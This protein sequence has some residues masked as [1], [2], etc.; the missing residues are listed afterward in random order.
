MLNIKTVFGAKKSRL[1][2]GVVAIFLFPSIVFAESDSLSVVTL[3]PTYFLK[4]GLALL[5]VL[6][7]FFILASVMRRFNGLS[8]SANSGLKIIVALSLGSR[9]K[10]VVVEAGDCQII[11]G[12]TPGNINKIHVLNDHIKPQGLSGKYSF[13]KKLESIINVSQTDL[14]KSPN[15]KS[16]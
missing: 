11:L 6:A 16:S 3:S 13:K 14:E 9:E 10:L 5:L 15:G 8:S 7:M 4:L 2:P 12:V 1:I